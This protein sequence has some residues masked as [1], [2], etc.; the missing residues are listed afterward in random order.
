MSSIT[1]QFSA[2]AVTFDVGGQQISWDPSTSPKLLQAQLSPL[3]YW[4]YRKTP[5]VH[6]GVVHSDEE[7]VTVTFDGRPQSFVLVRSGLVRTLDQGMHVYQRVYQVDGAAHMREVWRD[8]IGK[9]LG[10]NEA[11][12]AIMRMGYSDDAATLMVCESGPEWNEVV[13]SVLWVIQNYAHNKRSEV[14]LAVAAAIGAYDAA[15]AASTKHPVKAAQA[16]LAKW[17]DVETYDTLM[18][19]LYVMAGTW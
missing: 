16:A 11:T 8:R 15:V 5:K 10:F 7:P 9:T 6:V 3:G 13:G 1:G 18:A 12:F 2:K 4:A 17:W 14:R 19:Y